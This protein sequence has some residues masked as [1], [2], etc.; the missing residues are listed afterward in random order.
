MEAMTSSLL[1]LEK[2]IFKPENET[3]YGMNDHL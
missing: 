1:N 2:N 3:I